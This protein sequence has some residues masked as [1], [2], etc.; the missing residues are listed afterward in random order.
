VTGKQSHNPQ[1]TKPCLI[2]MWPSYTSKERL[3]TQAA[4]LLNRHR[5]LI[6]RGKW[7]YH[8]IPIFML[9]QNNSMSGK[10]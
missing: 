1:P 5:T 4:N 10:F 3:Q 2:I 9:S 6:L 7:E 8:C